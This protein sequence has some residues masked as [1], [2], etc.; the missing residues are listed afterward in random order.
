MVGTSSTVIPSATEAAAVVL[1]L[2]ESEVCIAAAVVE[3]GT[4]MVAVIVTL[5]AVMLMVTA[6]VP[7]PAREATA[8]RKEEVS[9]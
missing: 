2:E 1:R 6:E 9:P 7:T 4:A 8:V 3:A 5:A